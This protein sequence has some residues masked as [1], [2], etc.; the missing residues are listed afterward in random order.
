MSNQ[1]S[2]EKIIQLRK[3]RSA[4]DR[5]FKTYGLIATVIGMAILFFL[6]FTIFSK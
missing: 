1:F 4:A 3:K 2:H 5:R 6:L